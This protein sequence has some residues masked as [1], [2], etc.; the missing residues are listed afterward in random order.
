MVYKGALE[1]ARDRPLHTGSSALVAW[2]PTVALLRL[3]PSWNSFDLVASNHDPIL[4]C[5]SQQIPWPFC[6]YT[7]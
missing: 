2:K 4:V 7:Y 3:E 1:P 5:P 6:H